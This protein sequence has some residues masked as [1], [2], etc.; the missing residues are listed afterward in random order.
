M[1]DVF[2]AAHLVEVDFANLAGW[3]EDDH[4][5]AFQA[6]RRSAI[7]MAEKPS[8]TKALGP[9]G[10]ALLR[11]GRAA[12]ALGETIDR[13]AARAFFE[14]HFRPLR[15][16]PVTG[17]G[18]VTGFFEPEVDARL[19]P[20]L[21]FPVPLY[22]PP[23]GLREIDAGDD[24][25]DLDPSLTWAL[26]DGQG[27]LIACPDRRAIMAGALDGRARPIAYV[28]SAIEAFFIH[29]QGAARLRLADGDLL[30]ISFAGKSGHAYF[31]VARLMLERGVVA[32]ASDATADTLRSWLE[33]LA[34]QERRAA[35]ARNPSYIFFRE[36]PV[37][38]PS[39]GP[40]A[41]AG[42]PLTAGRS[43]AVDR[44]QITFHAPVFVEAD[45]A[46]GPFRRLMVAQDTGSAI[47]GPA[48]GDI[49]FGSGDA[50]FAL[51]ARVRD[52]ARFTLLVPREV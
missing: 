28:N 5:A 3:A 37:E 36:A 52:N 46:A 15:V 35:L 26:D 32:R 4:A 47:V 17:E 22:E 24:G 2:P 29:V 1:P 38:D 41:A 25:R 18:F 12:L 30:R 23:R 50:A 9:D 27:I 48:R 20:S 10:S 31:P 49:F 13:A 34:P 7:R 44:S 16:E 43:L 51:A 33:S 39:L 8:T 42:V 40:I 11:Q 19:Q 14:A 6:F 21:A 45:L